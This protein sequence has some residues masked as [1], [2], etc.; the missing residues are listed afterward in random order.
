M[1]FV[2]ELIAPNLVR[3]VLD[4][5]MSETSENSFEASAHSFFSWS[6][7]VEARCSSANMESK[8]TLMRS[9]PSSNILVPTAEKAR[10]IRV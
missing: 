10:A 6:A 4:P 9:S 1:S 5:S 8:V 3:A 2:S 7:A